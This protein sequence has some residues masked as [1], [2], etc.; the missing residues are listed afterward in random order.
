MALRDLHIKTSYNK[1]DDDIAKSF[2]L[3]CLENSAFYDRATGYFGSTIYLLCWDSLKTFVNNGGRM[4]VLCSPY[5]SIPDQNA[6]EEA[7]LSASSHE[8]MSNLYREFDTIFGK[9]DISS[10]NRV[11]ACLIAKGILEV[12]IAVGKDDPSRLFHDKV[13]IFK[14]KEGNAVAFRGSINETFKGLSNDGNFESLDS[15][16]NWVAGTDIERVNDIDSQFKRIWNN[17]N[18]KVRAFELP[19]DIKAL[20]K[21][22]AD[23]TRNWE[24]VLDEV[25]VSI[26][27]SK[28]WSADKKKNGKKPRNHQLDALKAW[29]D[30]GRRGIFEH[31]TGSGK[32]FTAMCAIRR[33]LEE[34]CPVLVLVPSVGL[35]DQWYKELKEMFTD[36]NVQYLLCGGGDSTWKSEMV[37]QAFT[38]PL[39]DENRITIAVMDTASSYDFIK[40]VCPSDK[41]LLVADEAHRIGSEKRR[42]IFQ[43]NAGYRLAL[44][45]TP[46]R[47]GDP[48]GTQAMFDYFGGIVGKPYSLKDAIDDDVLCH[49]FYHP[50]VVSLDCEEQQEWDDLSNEISRCVARLTNDR[51]SSSVLKNDHIKQLLIRRS[52]VV[53]NAKAKVDLAYDVL[54]ENYKE[55]DRWIVYCD[56][57][58]Q[59]AAVLD[60]LNGNKL[61]AY[62]YHS[63]LTRDVKEK[64]LEYF[65]KIG[66]IVV[67]IR[68][69]DEGIDI[70]CTTHALI[71]ASSQNPREFIQRRG[72]ILRKS[73]N[74]N[75]AYLHDA[76]VIPDNFA[77]TDKSANII[78]TELIRAIQF[79]EW[80]E[81]SKCIVD[82]KMLAVENDIDYKDLYNTGLSYERD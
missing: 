46:K 76:I 36:M 7:L 17:D 8:A 30:N 14:D 41:L 52:R 50:H 58:E 51:E 16:V 13:G 80:A 27:E 37:V 15:F 34:N 45:A 29:Q 28:A 68:C 64:T 31:A 5:L 10:P 67:S 79:G 1:I 61:R 20:I 43:I 74:K 25:I 66:G 24:E 2:Y 63:E 62:E 22:H 55:G 44:S 60:K 71:L 42:R 21:K 18:E 19:N 69:L 75:F 81:D 56:N 48:E 38:N 82:L 49:Y 77:E 57:R 11:L 9:D 40:E 12:R 33:C 73:D 23:K 65:S 32:T 53:K 39:L 59:M 78:H 72:R 70:P 35:L 4:R 3:P 47:Y 26:D 6:I 54:S